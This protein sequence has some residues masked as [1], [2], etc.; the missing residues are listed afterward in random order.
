MESLNIRYRVVNDG[1]DAVLFI[2]RSDLD[3][4]ESLDIWFKTYGYNMTTE[5]PVEVFEE[6]EFC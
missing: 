5:E 3:K 2:S 4:L 1:D 6:L